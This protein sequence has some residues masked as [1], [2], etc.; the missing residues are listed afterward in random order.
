MFKFPEKIKKVFKKDS[1]QNEFEKNGFVI[2]QFYSNE[3]IEFLKN[4]YRQLHPIDEKGFFPSTFSKDKN[5]RNKANEE[6]IRVGSRSMNEYLTDIKV[7]CGSFIVKSPGEDSIMNVHQDMTLVDE[8]EYTGINIWCPLVDLSHKNGAL[9][10]LPG[11]HRLY[12][13]YRGSSVPNIYENVYNE[14]K[15]YMVPKYLKAGEAIIFD[16]SIIHYSPPNLSDEIRP[17]TNTYFTHKDATFMTAYYDKENCPGKIELFEQDYD[18]MTNFEQ[19]GENIFDRPK[20]GKSLVFFDWDFPKLTPEYLEKKYG[21]KK[22]V[23]MKLLSVF[24]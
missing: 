7:V 5:Y 17:V 20:I 2:L 8:S 18:F 23:F 19:F 15:K 14:I 6:I 10:V 22:S 9:Y 12:P 13:T 3:E 1:I 24:E 16:Q 11:S 21:Q 4:L